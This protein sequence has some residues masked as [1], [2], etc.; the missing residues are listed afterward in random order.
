VLPGVSGHHGFATR[1]LANG[2]TD[3]WVRQRTGHTTNELLTYRESAKSLQELHLGELAPLVNAIPELASVAV[4]HMVRGLQSLHTPTPERAE[5][6]PEGGP[7]LPTIENKTTTKA[8][9]GE[10]IRTSDP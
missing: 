3:D 9:R 4:E 2:K 1:S 5:G 7:S 8:G 6:G 10:R